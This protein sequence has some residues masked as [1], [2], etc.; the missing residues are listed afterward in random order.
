MGGSDQREFARIEVAYRLSIL[1][2]DDASAAK[3][4]EQIATRPSVWALRD[5]LSLREIVD[6]TRGTEALLAQAI[7]DLSAQI[8]HLR[9]Q[10]PASS[11]A[12]VWS[13]TLRQVSGG[14]GMIEAEVPLDIGD[15]FELRFI[16]GDDEV[17]HFVALARII[18]RRA[19]GRFGF[20]FEAIHPRDQEALIRLIYALQRRALRQAE[21]ACAE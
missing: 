15:L 20:R 13:A 16:D 5:E 14:G 21:P 6:R 10:L 4:R 18:D 2:L 11:G 7:L 17:P 9:R 12:P 8:V 1:P 19:A 3:L